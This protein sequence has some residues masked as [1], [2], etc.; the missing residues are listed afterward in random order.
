V[1]VVLLLLVVPVGWL[2]LVFF[3]FFTRAHSE[4]I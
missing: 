3:L 4:N 2:F 1:V